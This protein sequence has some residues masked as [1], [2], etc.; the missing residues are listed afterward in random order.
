METKHIQRILEDNEAIK[1]AYLFG[2]QAGGDTGPLSDYDFAVYLDEELSEA[3]MFE[4]QLELQTRLVNAI[5][6]DNVDVAVLNTVAAPEFKYNVIK[7]GELLV[8]REPYKVLVEPRI[9][10]EYFDFRYS[11]RKHG[12]TKA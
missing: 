2:S 1:L 3:D 5:G 10:T 11:L 4:I 6:T 8:E 9:M 7:Y 12:L